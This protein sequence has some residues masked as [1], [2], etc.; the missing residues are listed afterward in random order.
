MYIQFAQRSTGLGKSEFLFCISMCWASKNRIMEKYSFNFL[1]ICW[2]FGTFSL[3]SP[4]RTDCERSLLHRR[5]R[6]KP[7][8]AC[9][10]ISHPHYGHWLKEAQKKIKGKTSC[11]FEAD[12]E[13]WY[14][15]EWECREKKKSHFISP[16]QQSGSPSRWKPTPSLGVRPAE[17]EWLMD[18]LFHPNSFSCQHTKPAGL[19]CGES[20][21]SRISCRCP[22][23]T[24]SVQIQAQ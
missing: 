23:Q 11:G 5:T 24:C 1:L 15:W 2:D 3:R 8:Q 12:S 17:R 20:W 16:K 18:A 9:W 13:T 19:S 6:S 4:G 10:K 21:E 22:W 7:S 14:G